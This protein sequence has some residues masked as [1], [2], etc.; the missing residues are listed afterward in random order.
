MLIFLAFN[1]QLQNLVNSILQANV[2]YLTAAIVLLIPNL[3]L[4][5]F[6]WKLTCVQ[7]LGEKRSKKIFLSLLY[8]F[9]PALITPARTG[10]YFGR[11]IAFKDKSM[12]E[13]VAATF[14]DKLF[15]MLVTFLLGII[16]FYLFLVQYYQARLIISI[17]LLISF[18]L[19]FSSIIILLTG[20]NDR[21]FNYI[22]SKFKFK[23]FL[24]IKEKIEIFKG[25]TRR[26]TSRMFIVSLFFLICYLFQ[27][28]ILIAAFSHQLNFINYLWAGIL[29]LFAKT[30]LSPITL[31]ELGAR[32]SASIFFLAYFGES[33]STALNASLSLFFINIVIPSLIGMALYFIKND[34]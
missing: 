5:Y 29:I 32:E 2:L 6:K 18:V 34:D 23:T 27:L 8:G 11:G 21:L 17:P 26:Y 16:T 22:I 9:P 7:L 15:V 30:A 28:T 14:I 4:Q 19:V 33:A 24:T 12:L 13:I 25:I 10:E 31:G 20:K 1:I 3:Y